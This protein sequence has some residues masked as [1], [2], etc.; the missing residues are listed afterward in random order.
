MTDTA[1]RWPPGLPEPDR[2]THRWRCT[3]PPAE[4]RYVHDPKTGEPRI[5]RRCPSCGAVEKRTE[6]R[7][8]RGGP[9]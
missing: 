2:I 6:P 9:T 5:A 1:D 7:T 4:D 8:E 3:R